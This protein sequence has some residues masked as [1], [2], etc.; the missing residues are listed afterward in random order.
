VSLT[1]RYLLTQERPFR[2]RLR[3]PTDGHPV[4]VIASTSL[5]SAVGEGATLPVDVG[6]AEIDVVVA[7]TAERFPTVRG[8]VLVA[9]RNALETALNAS[10]PGVAVAD[11][12]WLDGP[13]GQ[14]ERLRRA[15]PVPV[16]IVSR[17]AVEERLRADPV[18]RASSISLGAG[19]L[20]AL[21]LALAGVL[22]A[23]AIDLRDE[24]AELFDLEALG[25]APS[26]LAR[27]VWLRALAVVALGLIGGLVAGALI[28]LVVTSVVELTANAT[29]AEPPLRLAADWVVLVAGL[30]TFAGVTLASVM[31]LARSAFR[32]AVPAR[33]E[34]G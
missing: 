31:L 15:A 10:A 24:V 33:A 12:V 32:A 19:V 17:A 1:L 11:E 4:P 3:Q 20:V 18:S 14:E 22:L 27:H 21:A 13:S 5:V 34:L 7:A 25:L 9:D 6:D 16:S 2:V 28:A 30:V 23:V 29:T 26:D 8:D